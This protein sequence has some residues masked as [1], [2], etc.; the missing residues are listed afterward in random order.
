MSPRYCGLANNSPF[1]S[2]HAIVQAV[3]LVST[4][5]TIIS[6]SGVCLLT[7]KWGY[8]EA[9]YPRLNCFY[10]GGKFSFLGNL[11]EKPTVLV[12][13]S[14]G[15][16]FILPAINL[17]IIRHSKC[18]FFTR[19]EISVQ[20]FKEG[21]KKTVKKRSGWPIGLWHSGALNGQKMAQKV[22]YWWPQTRSPPNLTQLMRWN[23]WG[24]NI[25]SC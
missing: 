23:Y 22:K 9:E 5:W 15:G 17:S 10:L 25:T 4:Y 18:Q 11:V 14:I 3:C 13:F 2:I 16:L 24:V 12:I 6:R 8:E 21:F 19:I 7:M 1:T 20:I